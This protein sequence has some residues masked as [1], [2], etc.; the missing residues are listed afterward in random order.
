MGVTFVREKERERDRD[1]SAR[2]TFRVHVVNIPR[3]PIKEVSLTL[4]QNCVI[5]P[6]HKSFQVPHFVEL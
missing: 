1:Q 3:C 6:A 2:P 4:N 5:S